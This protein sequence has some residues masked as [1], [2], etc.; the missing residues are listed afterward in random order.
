MLCIGI[1]TLVLCG[2]VPSRSLED[3][4]DGMTEQPT[5]T[6]YNHLRRNMI[7]K[8]EMESYIRVLCPCL[9]YVNS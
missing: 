1:E 7:K 8:F 6:P 3:T 5:N 2:I 9:A 4:E